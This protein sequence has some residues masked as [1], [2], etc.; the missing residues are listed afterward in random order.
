VLFLIGASV[1]ALGQA[2][3]TP[4]SSFGIGD[5]YGQAQ[6]QSQGMAG[7]GISHPEYWYINTQNPALLVFNRF[8][9]F[10]AGIVGESRTIRNESVTEKNTNGNLNYLAFSV[11][12]Y[13]GENAWNNSKITSS[14]SLQP[15][16]SVNY[17]FTHRQPVIG[18]TDS[19][20]VT[21]QG[22]GGI[23]A[24]SLATGINLHRYVSVGFKANYL[25]S[26]IEN[27]YRNIVQLDNQAI[28][29][30]PL[31][32]QRFHYSDFS[33]AGGV[34]VHIDS[35][36]GGNYRLNFGSVYDFQANVRTEYFETLVRTNISGQEISSD[37]LTSSRLGYTVIPSTW[38][39]GLSISKGENWMFGADLRMSNYTQFLNFEKKQVDAET[40]W[41]M[42]VGGQFIPNPTSL[43]S[44]LKRVTYRTGVSLEQLPYLVNG[45]QVRDF[46]INFGL[47]LPVSRI[48]SVDLG[49]RWGK[50]GN[51]AEH[52][53]D[54]KYFKIYFGVTFN[55]TWFIKR[56]F[57]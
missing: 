42:T 36:F 6:A 9:T 41:K 17:L 40:G 22:K 3:S 21:E 43:S 14:L 7:L 10:Q 2:A 49:F 29:F 54:E 5:Y 56:R 34:S 55:D 35:L 19:A 48:S 11:P 8:T 51:I 1:S 33:F 12:V 16:T 26:S 39:T 27:N 52:T 46:G 24:L 30:T 38:S 50:R 23:N 31:I 44:Y 13:R 28:V 20:D 18:T 4:F 15:Y 53:I 37:T 32:H 47:S 45:N 25:F 57:D